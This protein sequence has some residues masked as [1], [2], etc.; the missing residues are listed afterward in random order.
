MHDIMAAFASYERKRYARRTKAGMAKKKA[1]GVWCGRPP[2]GWRKV[3]GEGKLI[4]DKNE[5][6]AIREMTAG[7][8][9]EFSSEVI[10]AILNRTHGLCRGHRWSARTVRKILARPADFNP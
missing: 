8:E 9:S 6:S 7:A 1:A 3:K 4:E 2:I 10:T 5:Q